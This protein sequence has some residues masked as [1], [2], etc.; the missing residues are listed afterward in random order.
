MKKEISVG[1]F[2]RYIGKNELGLVKRV[3]DSGDGYFVW[4]HL[5]G[6]ASNSPMHILEP[7]TIQDVLKE[8]FSNEYA[9]ASLVERKLRMTEGGDIS[10]L[11]DE[12]HVRK[13]I[14]K[15]LQEIRH[16]EED[17]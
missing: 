3:N 1:Q 11:I 14:F 8:R 12:R 4:Y 6:T 13:E 2:V 17:Y 7:L 5:G 15:H 9:K 10:D 16:K